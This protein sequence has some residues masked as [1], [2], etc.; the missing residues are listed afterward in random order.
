[1]AFRISKGHPDG[2]VLCCRRVVGVAV[3][4][5]KVTLLTPNPNYVSTEW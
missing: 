3:T 4:D 1:M 5:F 2:E